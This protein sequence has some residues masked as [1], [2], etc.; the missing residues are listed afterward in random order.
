MAVRNPWRISHRRPS[1]LGKVLVISL[2]LHLT[3][4]LLLLVTVRYEH[5]EEELPPPST[6]LRITACTA[7]IVID[8]A[9]TKSPRVFHSHP[10]SSDD[11]RSPVPDQ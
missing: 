4:L 6:V 5:Q 9:A 2:W 11:V 7:D 3:L 8:S 1:R 10:S